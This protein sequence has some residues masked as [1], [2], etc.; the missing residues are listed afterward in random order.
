MGTAWRRVAGAVA[1]TVL[2]TGGWAQDEAAPWRPP[3]LESS[4]LLFN[5]WEPLKRDGAEQYRVAEA[6]VALHLPVLTFSPAPEEG[7]GQAR[8]PV[9][10]TLRTN[11]RVMDIPGLPVVTPTFNPSVNAGYFHEDAG[12]TWLGG[13]QGRLA[14]ADNGATGPTLTPAADAGRPGTGRFNE[15]DGRFTTDH[16]RITLV[17][18]WRFPGPAWRALTVTQSYQHELLGSDPGA[19]GTL[20]APLQGWYPAARETTEA[21]W[22]DALGPCR[23]ALRGAFQ[24]TMDGAYATLRRHYANSLVEASVAGPPTGWLDP[25]LGGFVRFQWGFD[26]YNILFTTKIH[27]LVAGVVWTPIPAP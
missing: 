13:V 2:S 25:R 17:S 23:I 21:R 7:G 24:V 11:A 26:D 27:E 6:D 18:R 10:F 20:I 15:R 9:W 1:C 12:R 22:E 14:H 19:F 16:W 3:T 8:W 4:Y 5:H